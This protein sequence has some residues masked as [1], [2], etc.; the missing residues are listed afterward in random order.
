MK[1]KYFWLIVVA[2]ITSVISFMQESKG[3]DLI[4]SLKGYI[5]VVEDY[6]IQRIALPSKKPQE[7]LHKSPTYLVDDFDISPDGS[8]RIFCTWEMGSKSNCEDFG[9]S[10]LVKFSNG[11]GT[12][13]LKKKISIFKPTFS[14][15]G[16]K[17]AYLYN[18]YETSEDNL[19]RTINLYIVSTDG[20]NDKKVSNIPLEN[21]KPSWFPDSKRL[22]V[23]TRN[24]E[25]V[26]IDIESGEQNKLINFGVAPSVS[27]DGHKISYLSNDID[28]ATRDKLIER[29]NISKSLYHEIIK[30]KGQ[31]QKALMSLDQYYL[32]HSIYIYDVL[33]KSNN[34]L[35]KLSYLEYPAVW[36]PDD[37]YLTYCNLIW[38]AENIYVV[39]VASGKNEKIR[40][41]YG[42]VQV[43]RNE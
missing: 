1:M 41:R 33:N 24:M 18:E 5:E 7:I 22:A 39:D 12:I 21:F 20:T 42:R 19:N 38:E 43:W 37:R 4:G 32:M 30:E 31:R 35:T 27:H 23:T 6:G 40:K 10:K 34:R 8:S 11:I 26:V 9:Y 16:K 3:H 28:D 29:Q 36:S 13:I 25:I 14:P 17:V 2:F 15:D